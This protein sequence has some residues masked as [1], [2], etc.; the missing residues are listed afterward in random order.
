M[1]PGELNSTGE[2]RI[3]EKHRLLRLKDDLW[4]FVRAHWKTVLAGI[5]GFVIGY[6]KLRS[7]IGDAITAA[8]TAQAAALQLTGQVAA[9]RQEFDQLATRQAVDL[10]NKRIDDWNTWWLAWYAG[11]QQI[12]GE[13]PQP[14][15]GVVL[16]PPSR[17]P[18][19][20]PPGG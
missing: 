19:R 6:W 20:R 8:H 5:V 16:R 4:L 14:R 9:L 12:A 17:P 10:T 7:D 18:A 2:R 13:T 1:A 15:G 3:L 11:A